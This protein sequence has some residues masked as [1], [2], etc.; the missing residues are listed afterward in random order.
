[1]PDYKQLYFR[2]FAAAA[3]AVEAIEA[4]NY[5]QAKNILVSAQQ[6]AEEQCI[7]RD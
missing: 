2:L 6:H 1:M 7:A 5:G 3:D 4:L